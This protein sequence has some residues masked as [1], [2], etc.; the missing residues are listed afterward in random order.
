VAAEAG[1]GSWIYTYAV[2]RQL[3]DKVNA[4]YLTSVFWGAFALGRLVSTAASLRLS[5]RLLIK[6]SLAGCL[7]GTLPLLAPGT[8]SPAAA[9]TAAACFGFF[10]GP[11]FA[12]TMT[13]TGE[14]IHISGRVAGIFLVGTSLGGLFLPWLIGQLFEDVGPQVVPMAL[15]LTV[16]VTVGF[17]ALLMRRARPGAAARQR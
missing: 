15:L 12:N 3:A 4:A 13:L 6:L 16:I 10:V 2:T 11:L 1:F 17:Y 7:A 5:P 14:I 8:G 9:R